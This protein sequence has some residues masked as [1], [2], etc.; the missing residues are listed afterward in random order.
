MAADNKTLGRFELFGIPPAPRGIPQ[1]EVYLRHRRQ[2]HR[3]RLRQGSGHRP[4]AVH[5]HHRVQRPHQ[6]RDRQAGEGGRNCTPRRTTKSR[7]WSKPATRPTSLI[8]TTEKTLT[9]MGD[10]VD[11]ATKSDIESKIATLKTAMEGGDV[12]A[13]KQHTDELMK[14][15]HKLA[16]QMYAKAGAAG[17]PRSRRRR[18]RRGSRREGQK[19]RRRSGGGGVR[20]SEVRRLH[21]RFNQ[22]NRKGGGF[23]PF[24]FVLLAL[25]PDCLH[26]RRSYGVGSVGPGLTDISG[27]GRHLLVG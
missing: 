3:P 22:K 9:D 26:H 10:K 11:A 4:G 15:S 14:A 25:C 1:V 20:G 2:R 8:Y 19:A 18:R 5:P 27:H 13:M 6:G 23:P 16:E 17:R 21:C 7:R 24:L 12:A